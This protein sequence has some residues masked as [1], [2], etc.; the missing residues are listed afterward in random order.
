MAGL[1]PLLLHTVTLSTV[2]WWLELLWDMFVLGRG[3][4]PLVTS[5]Q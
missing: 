1:F 5:T 4:P 2:Y 3:I